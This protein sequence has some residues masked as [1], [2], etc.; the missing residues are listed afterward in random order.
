MNYVHGTRKKDQPKMKIRSL[1]IA[2]LFVL[3]VGHATLVQEKFA[4]NPELAGWKFL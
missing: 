3:S 4:A 1:A 2:S